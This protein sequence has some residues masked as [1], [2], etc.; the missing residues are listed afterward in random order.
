MTHLQFLNGPRAGEVLILTEGTW[1]LGRAAD[2]AVVVAD[3]SVSARHAELLVSAGEVM[4]HDLHSSN[5][6][7]VE[8]RRVANQ[9]HIRAGQNARIGTVEFRITHGV[10]SNGEEPIE[11]VALRSPAMENAVKLAR[12]RLC[13]H[14]TANSTELGTSRSVAPIAGSPTVTSQATPMPLWTWVVVGTMAVAAVIWWVL[15]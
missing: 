8:E 3:P 7:H 2:N 12:G 15:R 5:G 14:G 1:P 13:D 10:D 4:I 6:T 11:G 9:A